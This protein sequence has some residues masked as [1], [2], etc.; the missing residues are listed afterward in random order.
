MIL[1]EEKG[2]EIDQRRLERHPR[3]SLG[4]QRFESYLLHQRVREAVAALRAVFEEET[5]D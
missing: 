4:D 5:R 3:F 2:P 1:V